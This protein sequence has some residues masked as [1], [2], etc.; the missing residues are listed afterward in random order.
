[1]GRRKRRQEGIPKGC[2]LSPRQFEV[3]KLATSGLSYD[4][5][6]AELMVSRSTVRTHLHEAY[7]RL[8]VGGISQAQ[9]MMLGAGWF[10]PVNTDFG[11]DRTTAA[12]ALYVGALDR[13]LARRHA[14][15]PAFFTGGGSQSLVHYF[16]GMYYEVEKLPPWEVLGAPRPPRSVAQFPRA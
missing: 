5:I 15:G 14:D 3:L 8:D 9:S 7:T 12:Q 4:A 13:L 6:A 2:P 16:R 11:D 1:M 10:D